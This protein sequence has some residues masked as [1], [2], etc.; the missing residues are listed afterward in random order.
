[1]ASASGAGFAVTYELKKFVDG[2]VGFGETRKF[3]N[4]GYIC[5]GLLFLGSI[6]IVILSILSSNFRKSTSKGGFF[7]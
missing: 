1:M 5:V 2:V 6:C 7:G 4:R 3:L